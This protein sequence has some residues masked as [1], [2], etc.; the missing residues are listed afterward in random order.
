MEFNELMV[1]AFGE[2]GWSQ[3]YVSK[4]FG[5]NRGILHKFYHDDGTIS[6]SNFKEIIDRI[7]VSSSQK[8]LLT[9]SFYKVDL[10]ADRFKRVERILEILNDLAESE[11]SCDEYKFNPLCISDAEKVTPIYLSQIK[12]AVD[13]I[14]EN[15]APGKIY[16]NYPYSY[17]E[18][19]NAVF[20]NYLARREKEPKWDIVHM[21]SFKTDGEDGENIDSLFRSVKW[22][23][24]QCTPFYVVSGD[25]SK[26]NIPYPYFF[27]ADSY[28]ILFNFKRKRGFIVKNDDIF[29]NIQEESA[30]FLKRAV[31]L[32]SYPKD[33][34]ELKNDCSRMS[35]P[36]IEMS[37][38]N[39]P[40]IA[41]IIC[42]SSIADFVR[43]DFPSAQSIKKIGADHYMRLSENDN[44][45]HVTSD[46]GLRCLIETGRI[47]ECPPALIK[48]ESLP[49]KYRKEYIKN[50]LKFIDDE[51]F[52]IFDS[53]VF[54]MPTIAIELDDSNVQLFCV[55]KDIPENMQY[56]GNAIILLNDKR[57]KNDIEQ[58][59]EYLKAIRGIYE[60]EA[61]R[62]YLNSMLIMCD[63]AE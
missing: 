39:M 6:R 9:E 4:Q 21:I 17:F 11:V 20:N 61:A 60:K 49:I 45:K 52:L 18:F 22:V 47:V 24:R 8:R 2:V 29:E 30:E 51:R 25:K 50:M 23:E 36:K 53:K 1:K 59:I 48:N 63:D 26:D 55:F 43:D 35:G 7:P 33:M 12:M 46:Y 38:S 54:K 40:C 42:E 3:N 28:C 10:G 62:E 19:D 56:Y 58:F 32:A 41:S 31:K 27:A 57:L 5:I 14:F 44:Q 15:A 13:Y 16:T 37:I 34:F